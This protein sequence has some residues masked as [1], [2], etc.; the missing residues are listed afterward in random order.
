MKTTRL[1][2]VIGNIAVAVICFL[3]AATVDRTNWFADIM[4]GLIFLNFS[5]WEMESE[6]TGK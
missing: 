5:A 4:I 2:N 6:N 3:M 1:I